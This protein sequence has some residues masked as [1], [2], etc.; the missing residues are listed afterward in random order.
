MGSFVSRGGVFVYPPAVVPWGTDDQSIFIVGVGSDQ[1]LW[2]AELDGVIDE[3]NEFTWSNWRSLGGVV[4]SQ[5]CA[6]RSG[7]S[8]VDVFAAGQNCELLHW[9]FR[10]GL[11]KRWPLVAEPASEVEAH[12][13]PNFAEVDG[14]EVGR[15]WESLGGILTSPPSAT[16]FGELNDELLVFVLG[17]DHALWVRARAGDSWREWETF[18]HTLASPPSAVTWQHETSAVFALGLDSAVWGVINGEWQSLGGTWAAG[19]FA[20]AA[21]HHIHV[22]ATALDRT[23]RHRMWDGHSWASWENL[24]GILMS[25]PTANGFPTGDL[26][27]VFGVGT[28]SAIWRRRW[29]GDSW[30]DWHSLRG[31]FTSPPATSTRTPAGGLLQTRDLAALGVDHTIWHMNEDDP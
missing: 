4:T 2:Y 1:A 20:V 17:T 22:F 11:W 10:D 28:D 26:V 15:H 14:V 30:S 9:E 18:G 5:P 19:P 7:Q 3:A 13:A 8:S 21:G 31:V 29:V 27:H 23:L 24:G 6:V 25:Q 16:M 12:V